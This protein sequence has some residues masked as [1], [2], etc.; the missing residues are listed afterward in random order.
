MHRGL[1]RR[2][3]LLLFRRQH[4]EH[5]GARRRSNRGELPH[6][7]SFGCR[8]LLDLIRITGFDS[9]LQRLPGLLQLLPNWRSRLP[10]RLE[11]R[12]HLGLLSIGEVQLLCESA[13]LV[14]PRW[15]R[16]LRKEAGGSESRHGHPCAYFLV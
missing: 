7:G 3:L 16:R 15:W 12:L 9:R 6:L 11:D 14:V 1:E 5:L 2:Q 8:E 10:G 13:L 4:L